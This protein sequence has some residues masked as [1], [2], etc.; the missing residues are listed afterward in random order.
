MSFV[1]LAALLVVEFG[2]RLLTET[3]DGDEVL[4]VCVDCELS[5][6]LLTELAATIAPFCLVPLDVPAGVVGA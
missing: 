6:R 3:L 5:R 1:E 4:L 2:V